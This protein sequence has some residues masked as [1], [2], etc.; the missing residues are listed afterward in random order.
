MRKTDMHTIHHKWINLIL[1]GTIALALGLLFI[2]LPQNMVEILIKVTGA[3]LGIAGV[4]ML[5]MTY[6]H[7]KTQGAVNIFYLIQGILN[8]I[9]G[10]SMVA[11]PQLMLQFIFF[12]IGIWTLAV[13][14]FQIIYAIQIRKVVNSAI[15]LLGNGIAFVI[16]GIVLI[17]DYRIVTDILLMILGSV[18][19]LLGLILI[20]FGFKVYKQGKD[21]PPDHNLPAE[22]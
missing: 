7:S 5:L 1:N 12:G 2:F 17:V 3:L 16:V 8:I 4:V 22:K 15:Y 20:Y 19:S 18:L 9:I 14:L 13:G 11:Q 10:I 6:F 21:L